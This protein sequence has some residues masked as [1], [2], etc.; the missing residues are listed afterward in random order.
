[1]RRLGRLDVSVAK[2]GVFP[3]RPFE[4]AT[5]EQWRKVMA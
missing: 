4:E 3:V 1:V 2:A 5:P